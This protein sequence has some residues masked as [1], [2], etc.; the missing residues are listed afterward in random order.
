M[1]PGVVAALP[2]SGLSVTDQQQARPAHPTYLDANRV[3]VDS[4]VRHQ[5]GLRLEGPAL[6]RLGAH[7]RQCLE[8]GTGRR[9]LG[10]RCAV[11]LFGAEQV[12]ALDLHPASVESARRHL[13][14]LGDRV[15]VE[16]GDATALPVDDD[17]QDL[18]VSFHTLHHVEDW[19]TAV[20]E[21]ARVL[22]PGGRLAVAE[23]TSRFV[24]ARWLRPVSRHPADRF[25]E[26]DLLTA[27]EGAGFDVPARAYRS[28]AGGRW[29]LGV[30]QRR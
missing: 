1:G 24:D 25:S 27:L 22:H 11:E 29:L 18:V 7:G 6:A 23:M 3:W 20:A 4:R 10:A 14:D 17:S 13:A 28:R 16:V 30:A 5:A 26:L 19:R 12:L 21:Y 8:V 9:G 15:R 2:G